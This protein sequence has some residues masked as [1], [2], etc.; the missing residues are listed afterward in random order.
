MLHSQIKQLENDNHLQIYKR[1][2]LTLSHGKGCK[3]YDDAGNEYIDALGGIA[4]NCL[5]H[6]HPAILDAINEQSSKLMHISNLYYNE[7]QSKLAELLVERSGLERAFFCNSGAEAME[8]AIKFARK[9]SYKSGKIGKILSIDN[10]FHGRTLATIAMGKEKYQE[11][12]EPMPEGFAKVEMNNFVDL[13]EKISGGAIALVIEPVLGEGGVLVN[14]KKF[15]QEARKLCDEHNT[16][17]IFDE[18]QCGIGRTGT[19]FAYENLEVKP[20]MIALAKGLGAGFPIGAVLLRQDIADALSPGDHGT[21]FGG[22]P[23]ACAVSYAALNIL[24]KEDLI[25]EAKKKGEYIK[26]RIAERTAN[27][28]SV[29]EVRGMGLMLGVEL[30]FKCSDVVNTMIKKGVL[31]NCAA[32]YTIR[33]VPPLIISYDELDKVVDVMIESIEEHANG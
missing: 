18:I 13:E 11:G 6:A 7:P 31:A 32:L 1:H 29:K 17:L 30:D 15:L 23:L 26:K 25:G 9:Y 21:T 24:I 14:D 16:L 2:D 20:D 28:A 3:V 33:L 10:C 5:G 19:M 22:N 27:I 12:F 8:A 4:V